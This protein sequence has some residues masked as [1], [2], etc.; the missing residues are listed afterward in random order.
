MAISREKKEALVKEYKERLDD[1]E[2][3][4]ITDYRGLHVNEAEELRVAIRK[5]EGN[6]VVVKN[7]LAR[8]AL[9][10]AG[11]P[12]VDDMLTGPVGIGFCNSNIPGVA[13]AITD[14]AKKNE[15]LTVTGGLMGDKIIDEA[16]V[17]SLAKLPSLDVLRAQLL[18]LINA[19]ATQ[20]TGVVAAGVRQLINV[21]NA[22]AE[23]NAESATLEA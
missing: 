9:D 10:N 1:S 17:S 11:W 4:I 13:K 5:A 22:Y 12:A 18:G 7:T 20:L 15:A 6:F 21:V 2:A 14:F 23:E 3:I 8:R 16:A 19:P